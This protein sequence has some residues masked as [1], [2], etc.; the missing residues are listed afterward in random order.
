MSWLREVLAPV[1]P[2]VRLEPSPSG[3]PGLAVTPFRRLGPNGKWLTWRRRCS[4]FP[5]RIAENAAASLP[6]PWTSS[7]PSTSSTGGSVEHALRAA[8]QVQRS[9]GYVFAGSEPA[10]ME[11]M[12]DG[13]GRST[14]PVR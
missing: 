10:L 1:K 5:G 6:S 8:V 4:L 3:K 14:R 9:V 7:R 2:E 13:I 12:L 11:R